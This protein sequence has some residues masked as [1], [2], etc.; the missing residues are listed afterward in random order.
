MLPVALLYKSSRIYFKIFSLYIVSE[1]RQR[2]PA[3]E[4]LPPLAGLVGVNLA[5]R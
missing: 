3:S 2:H 4:N 5:G 1:Y